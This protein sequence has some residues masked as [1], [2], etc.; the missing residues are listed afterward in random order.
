MLK[1][2]LP[3]PGATWHE[4]SRV[5]ASRAASRVEARRMVPSGG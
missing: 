3:V 5:E 2:L 1:L 4:V